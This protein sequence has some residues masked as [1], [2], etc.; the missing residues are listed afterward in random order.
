MSET[1]PALSAEMA[2]AQATLDRVFVEDVQLVRRDAERG[3][4]ILE[5]ARLRT[6]ATQRRTSKGG[7]DE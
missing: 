3:T 6:V 1:I 7:R 2:K 4:F 5:L